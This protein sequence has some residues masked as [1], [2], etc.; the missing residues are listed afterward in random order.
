ML[1]RFLSERPV[2]PICARERA[3]FLATD[4]AARLFA[5]H[6][7]PTVGDIGSGA[8]LTINAVEHPLA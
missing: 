1:L 4:L 7:L 3:N 8:S 5:T 6:E 2:G